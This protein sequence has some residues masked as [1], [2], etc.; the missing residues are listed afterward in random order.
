MQG[1]GGLG[2]ELK[3]LGLRVPGGNEDEVRGLRLSALC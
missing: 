2:L 3:A 1:L